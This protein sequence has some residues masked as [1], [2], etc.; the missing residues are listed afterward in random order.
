MAAY[1]VAHIRRVAIGPP[2][3]EYLRKIDATLRPFHG[4]FLVHGGTIEALEGSWAGHLV[5]LEF[6]DLKTARDWYQSPAYQAIVHLRTDNSDG[7]TV[8]VEGVPDGHRAT[9]I[10]PALR[11]YG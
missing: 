10:L 7:D 11:S 6:P 2:I 1:A 4:R 9:D 3:E 5:V 8:L